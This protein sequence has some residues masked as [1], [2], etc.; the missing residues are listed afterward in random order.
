MEHLAVLRS[1]DDE[2]DDP[3]T[4]DKDLLARVELP[5]SRGCDPIQGMAR[6]AMNPKTRL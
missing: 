1:R 3:A 5:E 4:G 6:I 2:D